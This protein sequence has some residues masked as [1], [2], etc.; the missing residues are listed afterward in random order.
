MQ[1]LHALFA[2]ADA[3]ERRFL[4]ELLVGELRQ[5][6]LEGLL[7]EAI[8]RASGQPAAD[9]RQAAMYSGNVGAV[10]RAALEEGAPD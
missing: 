6:A 7:L 4:A 1:A 8:A 5:G 2:R 3:A 10:A 9:V